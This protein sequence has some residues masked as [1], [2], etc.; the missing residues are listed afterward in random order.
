MECP[1]CRTTIAEFDPAPGVRVL[2]TVPANISPEA[3]QAIGESWKA[4]F[5]DNPALIKVEGFDISAEGEEEE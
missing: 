4:H 2:V 3:M 1:N 5:P